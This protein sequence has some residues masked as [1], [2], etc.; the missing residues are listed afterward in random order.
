MKIRGQEWRDMEPEQKRK[1]IRQRA[2][3]NRDMVIEVQWE[4]MFKKNKPMFRLCAE[5]YRL[6]GGVLAK[7]IN[8]V[9]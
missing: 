2:V 1:L 6:S 8:Q 3:D 5:A 9:K 7:S 4:A